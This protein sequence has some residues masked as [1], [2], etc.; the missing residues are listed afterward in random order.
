VSFGKALFLGKT[1]QTAPFLRARGQPLV[2]RARILCERAR[3]G[4]F[5]SRRAKYGSALP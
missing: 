1:C 2:G 5:A 4:Y 3:D